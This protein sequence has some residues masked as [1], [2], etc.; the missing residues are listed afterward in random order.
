M[1]LE[2]L[3]AHRQR[4]GWLD[5]VFFDNPIFIGGLALPFAIM[6]TTSLK[7]AVALS[8][9]IACSLVA[10]VLLAQLIG[11][12]LPRPFCLVIYALFSLCIV[13][14]CSP[15]VSMLSPELL[16]SLGMYV[17]I[18]AVNSI[19]MVLCER[20]F[21]KSYRPMR[22]LL[23]AVMYSIGAA[24]ALCLM[25]VVR[26]VLGNN[27]IW[28]FPV[29]FPLKMRGLQIAFSG[30]LLTA[31][32]GAL[33]HGLRRILLMAYYRRENPLVKEEDWSE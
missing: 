11:N 1:K 16:D 21:H 29:A 28:G 26:E 30:F 22:A 9:V 18:A 10:T 13:I 4:S 19:L 8:I 2:K 31:F 20:S 7:S 25:A 17:P 14:A 3:R 32:F 6:I 23:D 12:W 5:G 33:F 24:F 27:T 15:L